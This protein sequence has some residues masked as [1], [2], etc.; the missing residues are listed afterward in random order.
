MTDIVQAFFV[1]SLVL[2]VVI[3]AYIAGAIDRIA[4]ALERKK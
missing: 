1:A 3:L 2:L 4:T